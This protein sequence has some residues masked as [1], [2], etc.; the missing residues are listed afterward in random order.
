M[1]TEPAPWRPPPDR[2]VRPPGADAAAV[3]FR[4]ADAD[5]VD[6]LHAFYEALAPESRRRRFFRPMPRVRRSIA[7]YVCSAD[8][9]RHAVWLA[10]EGHA[11]GPVVG[12]VH[13]A[14]DA[15]DPSRAELALA[16]TDRWAGRG[17]GRTLVA[18]GHELAAERGV[19]TLT[20]DVLG[21]NRRCVELLRGAG[22]QFRIS[23]G[24]FEGAGPVV[25]VGRIPTTATFAPPALLAASA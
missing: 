22:M 7:A 18:I 19:T 23:S 9:S 6:A 15:D 5:D 8:P 13:V 1:T 16:V 3:W 17:L 14:L 21:D 25:P 10:R 2:I 12:E 20:A 4:R 24:V 11:A